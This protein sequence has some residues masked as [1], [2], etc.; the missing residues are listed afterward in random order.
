MR[1]RSVP[2]G[3]KYRFA[4]AAPAIVDTET[5]QTTSSVALAADLT[6]LEVF[7]LAGIITHIAVKLIDKVWR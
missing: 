6:T 1:V 5:A 4:D 2:A 3:R 7:V